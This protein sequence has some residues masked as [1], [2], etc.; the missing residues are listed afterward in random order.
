MPSPS[1]V[2]LADMKRQLRSALR[3]L[4]IAYIVTKCWAEQRLEDVR[5]WRSLYAPNQFTGEAKAKPWYTQAYYLCSDLGFLYLHAFL[6]G[7]CSVLTLIKLG[8]SYIRHI[9]WAASEGCQRELGT[10]YWLEDETHK[11]PW[12]P[13]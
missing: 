9:A 12:L 2:R 10:T 5:G 3:Y 1:Y 8:A 7:H 13:K 4:V 6:L 11:W